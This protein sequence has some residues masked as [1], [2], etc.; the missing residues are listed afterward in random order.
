M[1]NPSSLDTPGRMGCVRSLLHWELGSGPSDR[2]SNEGMCELLTK[3]ASVLHVGHV[4]PR[5]IPGATTTFCASYMMSPIL[6]PGPHSA[7]RASGASRAFQHTNYNQ[8]VPQIYKCLCTLLRHS[9]KGSCPSYQGLARPITSPRVQ[10]GLTERWVPL[11][12]YL[13]LTFLLSFH[14][15]SPAAAATHWPLLAP[16]PQRRPSPLQDAPLPR[17]PTH[18]S[19]PSLPGGPAFLTGGGVRTTRGC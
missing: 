2:R 18:H 13:R 1:L 11:P 10:D 19:A 8:T 12:P 17:Q 9:P 15:S 5:P 4:V 16:L 6:F 14:S 7:L 3:D